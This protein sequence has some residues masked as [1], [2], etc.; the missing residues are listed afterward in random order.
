MLTI[1]EELAI[2]VKAI[3]EKN[4]EWQFEFEFLPKFMGSPYEIWLRAN[5][6]IEKMFHDGHQVFIGLSQNDK[7]FDR[8]IYLFGEGEF[9][10]S[11][12]EPMEY[13]PMR[14][15][16]KDL[17]IKLK[18]VDEKNFSSKA[19]FRFVPEMMSS[20][21]EIWLLAHRWVERMNNAGHEICIKFERRLPF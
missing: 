7:G 16:D 18:A 8:S 10:N 4:F 21:Y 19:D 5:D 1:N 6:C 15:L 2:S 20:S 9:E 14:K 3:D 13:S 11:R 12:G 17:I